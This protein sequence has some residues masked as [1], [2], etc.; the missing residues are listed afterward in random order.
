MKTGNV[1]EDG[2]VYFFNDGT[3]GEIPVGALVEKFH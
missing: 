1:H 3:Y 2:K